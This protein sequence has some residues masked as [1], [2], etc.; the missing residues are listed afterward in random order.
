MTGV[1][2][3]SNK[4]NAD[5]PNNSGLELGFSRSE[6]MHNWKVFL[7]WGFSG[8]PCA[9]CTKSVIHGCKRSH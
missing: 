9:A 6:W 2:T 7:P 1:V 8:F 3:L 5:A 4:Q